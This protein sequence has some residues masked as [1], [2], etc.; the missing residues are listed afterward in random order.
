MR[1]ALSQKED[2]VVMQVRA[3]MTTMTTPSQC[4]PIRSATRGSTMS[5]LM[6]QSVVTM[7]PTPTTAMP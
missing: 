6:I 7:P 4:M 3:P 2:R 5:V 1:E